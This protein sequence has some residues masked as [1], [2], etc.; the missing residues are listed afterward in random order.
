MG[1]SVP[2]WV[3][4]DAGLVAELAAA[5]QE[6]RPV[7]LAKAGQSWRFD[8]QNPLGTD[9]TAGLEALSQPQPSLEPPGAVDARVSPERSMATA[10]AELQAARE[11]FDRDKSP[12][13]AIRLA[14]AGRATQQA[15]DLSKGSVEPVGPGAAPSK[16]SLPAKPVTL[17]S[18]GG[19]RIR[20]IVDKE[21]LAEATEKR[22]WTVLEHGTP[23]RSGASRLTSST[24]TRSRPRR[25]DAKPSSRTCSALSK[26][27][28]P[29]R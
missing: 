1:L 21:G 10:T 29:R 20:K 23:W 8:P 9:E 12:Q 26:R 11:A 2:D 6:G 18:S 5:K 14:K 4:Q 16:K 19:Q 17:K 7:T 3:E 27:R 25:S 24:E 22:D 28:R 13:A 15:D